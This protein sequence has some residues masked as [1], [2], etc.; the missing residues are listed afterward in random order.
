MSPS[1]RDILKGG[2]FAALFGPLATKVIGEGRQDPVKKPSYTAK[3][4]METLCAEPEP[5][6]L[7]V[8]INDYLTTDEVKK[9]ILTQDWSHPMTEDEMT[10]TEGVCVD[11]SIGQKDVPLEVSGSIITKLDTRAIKNI[12][13]TTEIEIEQMF[14]LGTLQALSDIDRRPTINCTVEYFDGCTESYIGGTEKSWQSGF[15][16]S[17]IDPIAINSCGFKTEN[18]VAI[19]PD[20]GVY[21]EVGKRYTFHIMSDR[22]M[23]VSFSAYLDMKEYIYGA[24]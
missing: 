4:V 24:V 7:R 15:D 1:R 23:T 12:T 14:E 19:I 13:V 8:N 20:N 16:W 17:S 21:G 6:E 18:K 22:E 3:D 10:Y 9:T 2:A 5:F 11:T